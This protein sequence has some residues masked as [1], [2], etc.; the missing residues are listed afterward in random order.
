MV[1]RIGKLLGEQKLLADGK[2]PVAV[3]STMTSR[4]KENRDKEPGLPQDSAA[5]PEDFSP[6][7]K[8]GE[9]LAGVFQLKDGAQVVCLANHNAL[10][11]QGGLLVPTQD[12]AKPTMIW[13]LDQKTNQWAKLGTWQDVNFPVPPAGSAVFKF[14]PVSPL[15]QPK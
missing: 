15:R 9:L 6:Q 11:W 2:Q 7:I 8:Q 3:Y 4:S 13:E 1:S 14:S 5:F 10:A 12:K